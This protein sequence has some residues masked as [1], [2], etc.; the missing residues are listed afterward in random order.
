LLRQSQG[1]KSGVGAI[2]GQL[3]DDESDEEIIEAL[4]RV[5]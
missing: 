2:F 1:P 3:R 4:D 5:S